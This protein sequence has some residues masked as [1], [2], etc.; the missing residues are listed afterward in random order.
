MCIFS[1]M[2]ISTILIQEDGWVHYNTMHSAESQA[3][4]EMVP[5]IL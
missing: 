5:R 2:H 3:E 4:D 1:L